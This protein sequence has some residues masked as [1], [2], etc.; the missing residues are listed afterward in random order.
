MTRAGARQALPLADRLSRSFR[1]RVKR[2]RETRAK[3]P[4]LQI[5][6]GNRHWQAPRTGGSRLQ[7]GEV[8]IGPGFHLYGL[9][10]VTGVGV[11]QITATSDAV[12]ALEGT[13][14]PVI[15][16]GGIRFSGDIAK[17]T[18]QARKRGNGGLCAG[19]YRRILGRNRTLP[20]RLYKSIAG[21]AC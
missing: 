8:G 17:A 10:I 9:R 11:P 18:P 7:R 15:A 4:D 12:E 19:R 3:Y 13:G 6:G 2:I 14:I 1:R 5:I 21:W 20:G 16:D